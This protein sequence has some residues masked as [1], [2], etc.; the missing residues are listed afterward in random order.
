MISRKIDTTPKL[1]VGLTLTVY[2]IGER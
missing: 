2:V 1:M